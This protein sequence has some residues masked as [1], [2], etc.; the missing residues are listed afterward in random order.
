MS[1]GTPFLK[2]VTPNNL[3]FPS[4]PSRFGVEDLNRLLVWGSDLGVSDFDLMIDQPPWVS[5]SGRR[6]P[7]AN[8]PLSY[9]EMRLLADAVAKSAA[10]NSM[11]CGDAVNCSHEVILRRDERLRFR[12]NMQA[13]L[14]DGQDGINMTFR[15]LAAIPPLFSDLGVEQ[16]IVDNFRQPNGLT[17]VSGPTGSGKSTLMAAGIH[18]DIRDESCHRKW[19]TIESPIEYTFHRVMRTSALIMQSEV[20]RHISSFSRAVEEAMRRKPDAILVGE[21]RDHATISACLDAA[22]TGH[23]TVTTLH[24]N[25]VPESVRRIVTFFPVEER[26]SRCL[27]LAESLR[28]MVTQI[29]IPTVDGGR[30]ACREILLFDQAMR[31]RLIG[32][33]IDTWG[34]EIKAML[35]SYGQP[36]IEAVHRLWRDE[37]I[38]AKTWQMYERQA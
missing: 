14:G 32:A 15:A 34:V 6:Y 18:E 2:N 31:E 25:G 3:L 16:V 22:M 33:P 8:R 27:Q 30:A 9:G 20:P 17:T 5:I 10:N 24:S 38:D 1:T 21:C 12:V 36:M 11:A 35:R 26:T 29:L 13:V 4:F 7:V 19:V 28:L 37:R 23:Q